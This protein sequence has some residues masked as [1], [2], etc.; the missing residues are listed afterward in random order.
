[1]EVIVAQTRREFIVRS[2]VVAAGAACAGP[3]ALGA[4]PAA[5]PPAGTKVDI[6][7]ASAYAGDGVY[8]KFRG[9]GFF[10]VRHGADLSAVSAVCTHRGATLDSQ[11]DGTFKCSRHGSRFDAAGHVTRGP[12]RH[13]L[14][15]LTM[16][17]DADG[18]LWVQVP[19]RS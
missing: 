14:P 12:A 7:P 9:Q 5:G 1:M 4:D 11:A 3:L 19:P 15:V 2:L 6:G 17:P 13:D 16:T 8:G 18:H 10:V